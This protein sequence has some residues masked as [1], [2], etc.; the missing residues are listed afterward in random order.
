MPLARVQDEPR[1]RLLL[2]LRGLVALLALGKVA[3]GVKLDSE[4]RLLAELHRLDAAR[5]GGRDRA[6]PVGKPVHLV[7]VGREGMKLVGKPVKELRGAGDLD[8]G[9]PDL[10]QPGRADSA[11]ERAS[12]HL[13]P[14]ANAEVGLLLVQSLA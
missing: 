1:I 3:L 10:A 7:E 4:N 2:P 14:V 5:L 13:V 12:E 9:P 6:E 8:P 11:T